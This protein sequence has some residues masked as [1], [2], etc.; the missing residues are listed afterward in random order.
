MSSQHHP[1]SRTSSVHFSKKKSYAI[2]RKPSHGPRSR[3]SSSRPHDVDANAKSHSTTPSF[4]DATTTNRLERRRLKSSDELR[5]WGRDDEVHT[6]RRCFRRLLEEGSNEAED[7][8][9][10]DG[11]EESLFEKRSLDDKEDPTERKEDADC[12]GSLEPCNDSEAASLI[13]SESN[14]QVSTDLE[15]VLIP[16]G[17]LSS[18]IR[19]R[20]TNHARASRTSLSGGPTR[21]S[22]PSRSRGRNRHRRP[23][24]WK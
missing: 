9:V 21:S 22:W 20:F 4:A 3:A 19:S 23:R 17:F 6:L 1:S 10:N 12:E 24:E 8:I 2:R 13:E 15:S 11:E 16:K 18:S 7:A 5:V 14:E